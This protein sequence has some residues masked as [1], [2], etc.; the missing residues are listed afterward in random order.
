[1]FV[2]PASDCEAGFLLNPEQKPT[3]IR[4]QENC[5]AIVIF[6]KLSPKYYFLGCDLRAK[7]PTAHL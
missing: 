1:M 7:E 3:E 2:Q 4:L 6:Y 5:H